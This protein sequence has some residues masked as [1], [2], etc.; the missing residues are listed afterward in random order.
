MGI[1]VGAVEALGGS[2]GAPAGDSDG[3]AD[4][5]AVG[6]GD[7]VPP[8]ASTKEPLADRPDVR[9]TAL[10]STG[11]LAPAG[12]VMD[13][14]MVPFSVAVAVPTIAESMSRLT[15]S[16]GSK[17]VPVTWTTSDAPSGGTDTAMDATGPGRTKM[18][19][20]AS[21]PAPTR[22]AAAARTGSRRRRVRLEPLPFLLGRRVRLETDA[23]GRDAP[24]PRLIFTTNRQ[25]PRGHAGTVGRL[26]LALDAALAELREGSAP[27]FLEAGGS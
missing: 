2:V 18:R 17:P 20:K 26:V 6:S 5:S 11:D 1:G 4:P 12:T 14:L 22:V 16:P 24:S 3:S 7:A 9:P 27:F 25:F 21:S 8:A 23:L 19:R 13:V 10:T 15:T